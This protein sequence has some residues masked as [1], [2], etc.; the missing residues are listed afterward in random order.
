M[1]TAVYQSPDP[2]SPNPCHPERSEGPLQLA[3][4]T[5]PQDI[6]TTAR[7]PERVLD[8]HQQ[9]VTGIKDLS[10]ASA[11]GDSEAY[12]RED[13]GQR[14]AAKQTAT[15]QVKKR[16]SSPPSANQI[17]QNRKHHTHHHRSSQRKINRRIL[18]AIQKVPR[19]PPQRQV[20]PPDQHQHNPHRHDHC[21]QPDQQL[22]Q[23]SHKQVSTHFA[24]YTIFPATIV[25][26]TFVSR[27]SCGETVN[28]SRSSKTR[29]ARFPR[30]IVPMESIFIARAEFRV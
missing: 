22:T 12:T 8:L 16:K 29:S 19:Q 17:K 10:D 20:R 14:L 4:A 28:T 13:A 9:G 18:S 15:P 30:A 7:V 23:L 3:S 21:P 5:G 25:H 2:K 26:T 6:S 24:R 27:I 11:R 1:S